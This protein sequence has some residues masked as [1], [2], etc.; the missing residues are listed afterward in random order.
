[1]IPHRRFSGDKTPI[2]AS[3]W[4]N[5]IS[6]AATTGVEATAKPVEVSYIKA[7]G[8]NDCG[9]DLLPGSPVVLGAFTA[10]AAS[11]QLGNARKG[12]HSLRPCYLPRTLAESNALQGDLFSIGITLDAIAQNASG[13]VAIGGVVECNCQQAGPGWMS[14][15]TQADTNFRSK[16][17]VNNVWGV[18][19]KICD[20]GTGLALID[21]NAANNRTFYRL[22]QPMQIPSQA[23]TATLQTL[24][25]NFYVIDSF[26]IAQ[27]QANED[28]GE[29]MLIN[30]RWI[31]VNP[32]C[33]GD[34][35]PSDDPLPLDP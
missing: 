20:T 4:N 28:R 15:M 32:W 21:L 7:T 33:L 30:N 25:G 34:T 18:A 3:E 26:G 16:L 10:D 6:D 22:T 5:L 14:P 35:S 27:W 23:T 13:E 8:R 17:T 29:A 1:M 31:V 12:W 24:A 9:Y 2:S 19:R 11:P